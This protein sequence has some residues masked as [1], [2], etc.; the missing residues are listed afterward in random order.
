M[1]L[2]M[3]GT[4]KVVYFVL[5]QHDV[6]FLCS[7]PGFGGK[8]QLLTTVMFSCKRLL[9][10]KSYVIRNSQRKEM[11]LEHPGKG[12][13]KDTQFVHLSFAFHHKL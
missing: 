12:L 11:S 8:A 6:S 13:L 1:S 5:E 9:L 7:T 4:I 2:G 3:R 10:T